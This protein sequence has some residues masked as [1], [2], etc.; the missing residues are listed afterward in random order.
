MADQP[1]QHDNTITALLRTERFRRI[2]NWLCEHSKELAE[3]DKVQ[4][5]FDCAGKKVSAKKTESFKD[6]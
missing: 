6:I 3:L 2:I 4:I 1:S 5:V